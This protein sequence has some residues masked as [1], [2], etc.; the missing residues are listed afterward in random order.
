MAFVQPPGASTL[1]LKLH[2]STLKSRID[3]KRVHGLVG[4][5]PAPRNAVI[6]RFI[7]LSIRLPHKLL[8]HR[9]E[10]RTAKRPLLK[11][12]KIKTDP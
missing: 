3:D 10:Q 7:F 11:E 2:I 1:S 12:Y 8:A 5:D 9:V 4:R 6:V